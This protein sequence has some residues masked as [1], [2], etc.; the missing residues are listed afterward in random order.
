MLS[1]LRVV[2]INQVFLHEEYEVERL[3][4]LCSKIKNEQKVKNPPIALQLEHDKYLILDGAHRTLS[5][6][7]LNCKRIVIQVVDL[8][9][10]SIDAWAHHLVDAENLIEELLQNP[11]LLWRKEKYALDPIATLFV[12]NEKHYVYTAADF[13]MDVKKRIKI[14]KEIVNSYSSKYK[15]DR[16]TAEQ[17]PVERGIVFQYPAFHIDQIKNIVDEGLLLPAGVTKF[18]LTCGRILN[19][20][21]PL[22]FLIREDY[23]EEDWLELLALWR[24]S[25]RLYTDPVFL[26]EI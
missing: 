16:I 11:D 3:K 1:E 17:L 22:S 10:L 8:E 18:T 25:I 26:C 7:R 19:L 4:K 14:W 5:L 13:Y 23:V 9:Y 24:A 2:P 6:Q 15:F 12:G 20:N 21:I